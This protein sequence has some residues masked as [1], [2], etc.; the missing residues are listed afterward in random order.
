MIWM[1]VFSAVVGVAAGQFVVTDIDDFEDGNVNGWES[2][3]GET[4]TLSDRSTE[5]NYSMLARS[6]QLS[7][8]DQPAMIWQDGP[9][10][11]MAEEW[12]V[13][14]VI[15]PKHRGSQFTIRVGL[16]GNKQETAGENAFLIFNDPDGQ[17]YL[18]TNA[19]QS[20]PA[21]SDVINDSFNEDWLEVTMSS[22]ENNGTITAT[23]ENLNTSTTHTI[24]AQGFDG[25]KGEF[26]VNPG[27]SDSDPRSV[28]LDSV[29]ISGS[30]YDDSNL[31]VETRDLFKPGATHNYEVFEK[32][33][34]SKYHAWVD[35]NVTDNASVSTSN[36]TA[37]T[38][39]ESNNSLTA[40]NNSNVGQVVYVR[41]DY[42][43]SSAVKEVVVAKPTIENLAILPGIWRFVAV[44]KD[45]FLFALLIGTLLAVPATRFSSAFGGL[46]VLEMVLV[47]GWFAGYVP[48]SMALVSIFVALFIGLNLAA[49][50]DYQAGSLRS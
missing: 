32:Y 37:L 39:D 20:P 47:V 42:N 18:S 29:N 44:L 13:E 26:A 46:A 8:Q 49:N 12:T 15:R 38:V 41:A 16:T 4:P 45:S 19:T 10:L 5:G 14:M 27:Y 43:N 28:W 40:T 34:S 36:S 6:E 1:L 31:T 35:E 11:D 21:S 25:I 3:Q 33:N 23:I 17:T 50:I 24:E 2:P 48:L 22:E 7:N 9:T 30:L